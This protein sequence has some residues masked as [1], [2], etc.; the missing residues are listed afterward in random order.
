MIPIRRRAV[1]ALPLLAVSSSRSFAEGAPLGLNQRA[2]RRGLFF[3]TAVNHETVSADPAYL[4]KIDA[5]SGMVVGEASFKWA[6]IHPE[7]DKF[8]FSRADA[9]MDF[10]AR[11]KLRVRGHVMAWHEGNPDWLEQALT[12]ASAEGLLRRHISAVGK[13]FQ[14]RLAHWDVVNEVIQPDDGKLLSLRNSLWFKA[15]GKSYLDTA[16][17]ATQEADPGALRV[18]N[19]FGVDYPLAWQARK[20]Q[21]FL[22][23]LADLKARNIPVQAVGLQAH[24][25]AGEKI[26]QKILS[27]FVGDIA[28]LGLKIIVTE[29]DVRDQTLPADIALRDSAVAAHAKA[30]LDPVL[31]NPNVL[32]VLSWGLSDRHSWLNEK[33][34]RPDKLDQRALPLD[35]ELERKKLWWSIAAAL[36]AAPYRNHG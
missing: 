20:R 24:L 10:A 34:P 27:K 29:L 33:F 7:P 15:L 5:D 28:S 23:L 36:D 21:A 8:D 14:G 32:G 11:R 17:H 16:F 18:I 4:D 30:W 2:R 31:A 26:D 1:L 22:G 12:P 25:D 6:D 13:H 3:G 35:K 19:E 9:L